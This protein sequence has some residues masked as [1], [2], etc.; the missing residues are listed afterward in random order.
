MH[1]RN[2]SSIL[3]SECRNSNGGQHTWRVMVASAPTLL[4]FRVDDSSRLRPSQVSQLCGHR[5]STP[6]ATSRG[7]FAG[8]ASFEHHA[9]SKRRLTSEI[10]MR[11]GSLR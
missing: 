1:S 9:A 4:A 3:E 5:R 8:F 11:R 7:G 6:S 10:G 2:D